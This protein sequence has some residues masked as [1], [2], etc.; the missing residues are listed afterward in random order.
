MRIPF[1]GVI[2]FV[3]AW[4][5]LWAV[6]AFRLQNQKA[7]RSPDPLLSKSLTQGNEVLQS[8]L[9]A[10]PDDAFLQSQELQRA[11]PST[12]EPSRA[13]FFAGYDALIARHPNDL[14]LRRN[15]ARLSARGNLVPTRYPTPEERQNNLTGSPVWL[16]TNEL[17]SVVAQA[18]AGETLAPRDGFF[19]WIEAMALWGLGR[20]DEGV[21]A[22]ERAGRCTEF[23]DGLSDE[24]RQKFAVLSRS[25]PLEWDDKLNSLW[26]A[27]YPHLAG[28]RTLGREVA[29][30]GTARFRAGDK[31]GAWRRW[32]AILRAGS[33]V[34]RGQSG[35]GNSTVIG[36]LVGEAI[37]QVAWDFAAQGASRYK[38][39][40]H[41]RNGSTRSES[42]RRAREG[43]AAFVVAARRDG[44][45]ALATWTAR[46]AHDIAARRAT[47]QPGGAWKT[48]NT[49][50]GLTSPLGMATVQLRWIGARAM[51]FA[52]VGIGC[53]VLA[54]GLSRGGRDER[55]SSATVGSLVAF[56]GALW[57]GLGVLAVLS[58]AGLQSIEMLV[59]LSGDGDNV[60]VI[61]RPSGWDDYFWWAVVA[62]FI[63]AALCREWSARR[64]NQKL[65]AAREP[66]RGFD[67]WKGAS[68]ATWTIAAFLSVCLWFENMNAFAFDLDSKVLWAAWSASLL[69]GLGTAWHGQRAQESDRPLPFAFVAALA[70]AVFVGWGRAEGSQS[71]ALSWTCFAGTLL[72][73]GLWIWNG[74]RGVW[75]RARLRVN[76]ETGARVMAGVSLVLSLAYLVASIALLPARNGLN[77]RV[78]QYVQ[79]GEVKW[80]RLHSKS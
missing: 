8:A 42:E 77:A 10:H 62:T 76:F 16:K 3:L 1:R 7:L 51:N 33:A 60:P 34:R 64:Q 24:M 5:I 75:S 66:K 12:D 32:E 68:Y 29:L 59:S 4:M 49:Q 50:M 46:E 61:G 35:G 48:F 70:L 20:E 73:V 53:W 37:E 47:I 79:L 52:V 40:S 80:L 15:R 43:L 54:L 44:H 45:G 13:R 2:L 63:G 67:T 23:N 18:K 55:A 58:G 26:T 31:V 27:L 57:V 17:E 21:A 6:P 74:R 41:L 28:M 72:T 78:D 65:Q 56:F 9:R 36:Q 69:L 39:K 14:S 11:W 38:F 19:P 30:S 22:L 25:H 71:D